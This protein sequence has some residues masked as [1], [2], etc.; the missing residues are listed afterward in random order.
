MEP[1][2]PSGPAHPESVQA[3]ARQE[4]R[5][6]MHRPRR[7]TQVLL[8]A[9]ALGVCDQS[10]W[11]YS[12]VDHYW[13]TY[14]L[15]FV[16]GTGQAP[17]QYRV[18]IKLA[19]WWLVQ[20]FHWGFRHG[21]VLMDVVALVAAVL[22]TYNLLERRPAIRE[23]GVGLQWFAAAAVFALAAYYL[24]WVGSFL[25]PETLPSVGLTVVM[26][27]L[28]NVRAKPRY[29][30]HIATAC[31]L[32]LVS[33]AQAWIRADIPCALN[34]GILLVSL[35]TSGRQFSL[36]KRLA[37]VISF[38][39]VAVAAGTQLYMMRVLYPHASY[40]STPVF[41]VT[42]ELHHWLEL[43]PFL[44]FM[45]P[46]AWT[47]V[48][49]WRRRATLDGPSRGLLVGAAIYLVL[50]ILLGKVDEVRI[51]IPFAL[52]LTPLSAELAVRKIGRSPEVPT[53]AIAGGEA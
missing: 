4:L 32:I 14:W 31:A 7:T 23:A 42:R 50:W 53:A 17:E 22:L 6:E 15:P 45:L 35:T 20:H 3:I 51:F 39:C 25:R 33:A 16:H 2:L 27:W 5:P 24:G 40:G 37:T 49:A 18:G 38:L 29:G 43:P 9:L 19:A 41:M 21:F 44:V 36:P 28:W 48:Q 1:R 10:Y 30:G 11:Q 34:A 13:P 12:N 26:A 8:L 46:V 47:G 52:A